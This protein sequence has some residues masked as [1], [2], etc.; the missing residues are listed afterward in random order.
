MEEVVVAA[1]TFTY[2]GVAAK[3]ALIDLQR[4]GITR[5][6]QPTAVHVRGVPVPPKTQH[7]EDLLQSEIKLSRLHIDIGAVKHRFCAPMLPFRMVIYESIQAENLKHVRAIN[8]YIHPWTKVTTFKDS[9]SITP[10]SSSSSSAGGPSNLFSSSGED[11][12]EHDPHEEMD[13]EI[14]TCIRRR[15]QRSFLLEP[16]DSPTPFRHK[17]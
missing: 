6:Q 5:G 12:G 10:S 8:R 13:L 17:F 14:M 15:T 11:E 1:L 2:H 9:T 4:L 3:T 16:G 7:R